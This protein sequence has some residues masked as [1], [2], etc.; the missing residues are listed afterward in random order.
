MKLVDLRAWTLRRRVA[1]LFALAGAVL[2]GIGVS[3]AITAAASNQ[4][5]DTLLDKT[6]PMRVAG[7]E[8][9]SAYLDQE[10]GI[11]GYVLSRSAKNLEPY[12]QGVAAEQQLLTRIET[13]NA[14]HGRK[15][16][17]ADLAR[18]R[19]EADRWRTDVA[20][21]VLAVGGASG[22]QLDEATSTARFDAV[23]GAVDQLQ[24]DILVLR[25]EAATAARRTGSVLVGLLGGAAGIVLIAGALLLLLLDR[26]VT[27]PVTALAAQVREVAAGDYDREITS[28]GSPELRSLAAD[29]DGM[30]RRI[31]AELAEVRAARAQAEEAHEKLAEKADE[32]TR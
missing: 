8:L 12:Q 5:L 25:D 14:E 31:A 24:A 18:V 23:R 7:Q 10:T 13:L 9:Y 19:Q 15:E 11:R 28:S 27:R 1:I 26:L 4:H 16:I 21:P 22:P 32:L 29:V 20:Q 17:T 2:A 6:G 30:R 3:A